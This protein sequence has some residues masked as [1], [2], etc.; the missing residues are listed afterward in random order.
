MDLC[1]REAG[2]WIA[3]SPPKRALQEASE[4]LALLLRDVAIGEFWGSMLRTR[5]AVA[6]TD[7]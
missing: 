1:V 6:A 5:V 4:A 7:E 2:T 3:G